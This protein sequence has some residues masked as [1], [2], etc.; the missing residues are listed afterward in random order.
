MAFLICSADE[1]YP[2][3]RSTFCEN[4][5]LFLSRLFLSSAVSGFNGTAERRNVGMYSPSEIENQQ[6]SKTFKNLHFVRVVF[7]VGTDSM[8]WHNGKTL[9]LRHSPNSKLMSSVDEYKLQNY[10]E[11][12]LPSC[13]RSDMQMRRTANSGK[14]WTRNV[15][16]VELPNSG[17]KHIHWNSKATGGNQRER[18]DCRLCGQIQFNSEKV[19]FTFS[20]THS[21]WTQ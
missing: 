1:T 13:T 20:T 6:R 19:R 14:W 8:V 3:R 9:L 2:L 18:D 4:G 12:Y 10:F 16:I 11:T 15:Y 7:R 21:T 5:I 17:H